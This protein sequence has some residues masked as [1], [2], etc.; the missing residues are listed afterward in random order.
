M[1]KNSKAKGGRSKYIGVSSYKDRHGKTRYRYRSKGFTVNLGTDFGSD[2]FMRRYRAALD[3]RRLTEPDP[4]VSQAHG[5]RLNMKPDE[6]QLTELIAEWYKS[7]QYTRLAESTKSDYRNVAERLREEHGHQIV[8]Q[9]NRQTVAALMQKKAT[10]P[11]A[12]NK[13]LRVL[14]FI[15]DHARDVLGWVETN[16]ARDVKMY[17]AQNHEGFHTWD[18][19]EIKAFQERWKEGTM[20]DLAMALMLYTGAS[21][22]DVVKLGPDNIENG[23]I[24]YRRKK[25]ERRDGVLIDIPIHPD[26]DRRLARLTPSPETFLQT[27]AGTPRTPAGLGTKMRE[28]CNKAKLPNCSSHGLRK[29]C[30]RRL[31]EAGATAHEIASVTGHRTLAEVQRYTEAAERAGLADNAMEKLK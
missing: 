22:S 27:E 13:L 25:M 31:A 15:Y 28:W 18:E 20:A 29:A 6:H 14:R 16:P 12:A 2:D 21:R 3:G 30:A 8:E 17:Q 11:E 23:R 4:E 5:V 1:P 7:A 10:T 26:L 19:H 9:I 24:S